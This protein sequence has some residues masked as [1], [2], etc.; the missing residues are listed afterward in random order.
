MR[1]NL[2]III[3]D[4]VVEGRYFSFNYLVLCCSKIITSGLYSDDH[5]RDADK[6]EFIKE[7]RS[8]Y[9]IQLVLGMLAEDD[10]LVLS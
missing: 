2:E 9:A 5:C 6:E 1:V 8:G 3:T 10:S 4:V 7:L